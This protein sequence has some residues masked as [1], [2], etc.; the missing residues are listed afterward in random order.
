M[1]K[2]K[3]KAVEGY[4]NYL[5]SNYGRILSLVGNK[6]KLISLQVDRYGYICV[7]LSNNNHLKLFKVHRLVLLAFK[8]INNPQD[9]ECNHVDGNKKNNYI[10]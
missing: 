9:F 6:R 8:P 2:E 5:I 3:W 1:N 7:S 4:P 10:R